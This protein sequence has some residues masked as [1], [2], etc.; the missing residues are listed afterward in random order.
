MSFVL[1]READGMIEAYVQ[2]PVDEA[3]PYLSDGTAF[4]AGKGDGLTDYVLDGEITPR[5]GMPVAVVGLTVTVPP[6]TEFEV[7]GPI[8]AHGV[9]VDGV[10]EFEFEEPGTYN[11]RFRQF[12]F[13]DAEV[14]L[15][16]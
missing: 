7:L 2:A 4:L 9:A 13:L 5:P 6:G 1:Y 3:E 12:P 14:T 16:G 8:P 10:L 15:E 11:V